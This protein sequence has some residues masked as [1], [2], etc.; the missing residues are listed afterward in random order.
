MASREMQEELPYAGLGMGAPRGS[1]AVRASV[2]QISDT[3]ILA[4]TARAECHSEAIGVRLTAIAEH[5]GM[6]PGPV[7]SRSLRPRLE[8][9]NE[10]DAVRAFRI[11]GAK[12]RGLTPRGRQ[13]L[14]RARRTGRLQALPESP[15]HRQWRLAHLRAAGELDAIHE[16]LC[17]E[18]E[19]AMSLIATQAGD[20]E[21]WSELGLRL[22]RHCAQM[23]TAHYCLYEWAEPD[24]TQPD[25]AAKQHKVDLASVAV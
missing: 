7:R 1:D 24:D 2:E 23:A 16:Q 19:Q 22:R 18:L 4:A 11:H 14:A 25:T 13:R 9:L 15:E 17:S 10:A 6:S 3:L 8:A 21:A 20:S 5:L 12:V